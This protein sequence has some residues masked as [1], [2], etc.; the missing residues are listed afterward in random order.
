MRA[1]IRY[2]APVVAAIA[3][4]GA[5]VAAPAAMAARSVPHPTTPSVAAPVPPGD[6]SD[7]LVPTNTGANPFV[8]VPQGD[9]LPG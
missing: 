6:G 8:F 3:L 5:V 9:E 7:P 4:G 1:K 2:L